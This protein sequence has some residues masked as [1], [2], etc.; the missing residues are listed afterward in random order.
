MADFL[1][2]G[3]RGLFTLGAVGWTQ[4]LGGSRVVGHGAAKEN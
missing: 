3:G 2:D 4:A 1:R